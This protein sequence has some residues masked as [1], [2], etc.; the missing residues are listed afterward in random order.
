MKLEHRFTVPT[1]VDETWEAFNDLERVVPC[2]PGASLTSFEGSEFTGS[3]K[4]KLGPI[5]LLYKGSGQFVER[6]EAQHRAVLEAKGKDK[7]GNGTA[8]ATVTAQLTSEGPTSTAVVVET[9]LAVTGKPAQFGRGV[10]QDVSDKMLG[11]FVDCLTTKLGPGTAAEEV[12]AERSADEAAASAPTTE[13][14]AAGAATS[15]GAGAPS[16]DATP[17]VATAAAAPPSTAGAATEGRSEQPA[18]ALDLGATV[19]PV[20]A[21]RYGPYVAGAL[22][23]LLILWR[24]LRR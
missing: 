13:A 11:Q 17:P 3:C 5:S 21:R 22:V 23:V 7:R 4:V 20:L 15:D 16:A 24:I 6:D 1:S 18:A 2:F 9:D 19:L 10:M 14:A 8:S 12:A